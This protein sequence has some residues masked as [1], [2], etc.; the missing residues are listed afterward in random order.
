[1]MI[2]TQD[3]EFEIVKNLELFSSV[4]N[5]INSGFVYE[6]DPEAFMQKGLKGMLSYLDPYT[7]FIPQKDVRAFNTSIK[8]KYA[9]IGTRIFKR[10]GH[11]YIPHRKLHRL[12]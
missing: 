2:S 10:D 1:M 9:G 11:F 6:L 5:E 8:G 12:P 4:Y 3:D 7:V